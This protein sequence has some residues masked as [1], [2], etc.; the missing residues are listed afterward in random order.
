MVG[1]G[2]EWRASVFGFTNTD[3]YA[4][5]AFDAPVDPNGAKADLSLSLTSSLGTLAAG[6][7]VQIIYVTTNNVATAGSNAL[8]GTAG[9]DT[10]DG[11]GGDD[12]LI[13][14]GGADTF[15][16]ASGYGHNTIEDFSPGDGDRIDLTGVIGVHGIND[17]QITSSGADTT[18]DLGN[19]DSLTLAN[20][21]AASLVAG[22]FVF[23]NHAAQFVTDAT[24]TQLSVPADG[25]PFSRGEIFAIGPSLSSDGRYTA[26]GASDSIP[27]QGGDDNSKLGDV[28]LYDRQTGTYKWISDPANFTHSNITLH[29]GETFSGL[30]NHRIQGGLP[31]NADHQ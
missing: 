15:V 16:F 30:A 26:F 24:V 28:Y 22:D 18:I 12:L 31:G 8:Y 10:I 29:S 5:H 14:L 27:G 9:A 23:A 20:V 13:G 11:L 1:L 17:L 19:G 3:P 25:V 21:S 7:H 6:S 2:A 4:T